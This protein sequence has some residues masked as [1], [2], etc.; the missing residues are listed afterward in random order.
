MIF[1]PGESFCRC[2]CVHNIHNP[3]PP[4]CLTAMI[5]T[6]T[7]LNCLDISILLIFLIFCLP[8]FINNCKSPVDTIS[9]TNL[10]VYNNKVSSPHSPD[11]KSP[12]FRTHA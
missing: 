5:Y 8:D 3:F 1:F 11:R 9:R 6:L 4:L 10:A 12:S 2:V 7:N